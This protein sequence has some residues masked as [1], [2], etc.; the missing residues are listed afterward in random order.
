MF[1]RLGFMYYLLS[2]ISRLGFNYR[3]SIILCVIFHVWVSI[4]ETVKPTADKGKAPAN[5]GKAPADKGKASAGIGFHYKKCLHVWVLCII[6]CRIFHV[7]VSI[8]VC[9][10]FCV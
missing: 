3:L 9:L 1:T 5:K 10:L 7:W 2:N 8:A 6:F 4:T